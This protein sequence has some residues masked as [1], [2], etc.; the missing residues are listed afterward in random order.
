MTF[1]RLS[2]LIV[3]FALSYSLRAQTLYNFRYSFDDEDALEQY[4]AFM[5]RYDDGTGFIRVNFSDENDELYIVDMDMK[6]EYD[7]DEKTNE[8]DR[9]V[10][11]FTGINPHV[12][13]GNPDIIYE[14][15]IF[16]FRLDASGEYYEPFEVWSMAEDETVTVGKFTEVNLLQEEDL[17]EEFVSAFFKKMK[18]FISTCLKH[19]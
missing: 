16:V 19:P 18:S 5:V 8:L 7:L 15:D 2:C 9:S 1:K 14:P 11:Y 4:N 12:V 10:L 13:S 3:V 6:E 17:T